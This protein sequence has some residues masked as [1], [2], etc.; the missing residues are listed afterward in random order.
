[1][2]REVGDATDGVTLHL[3]IGRV[4]LADQWVESAQ[5]DDEDFVVC[6]VT[7]QYM[8][9]GW[10]DGGVGM[11]PS[12]AKLPRAALAARCTSISVL[13]RRKRMGSRVF[14]STGRTSAIVLACACSGHHMSWRTSFSNLGKGQACA[15]LQIDVV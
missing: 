9:M 5:L 8:V 14:L 2:S 1:M 6:Y 4:H 15:S 12:T 13:S 11:L 7:C 10:G 3:N